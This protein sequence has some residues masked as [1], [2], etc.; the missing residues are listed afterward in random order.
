MLPWKAGATATATTAAATK[1]LKLERKPYKICRD[2]DVSED[3]RQS[4]NLK[5]GQFARQ[6]LNKAKK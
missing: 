6:I 1:E 4:F 2:P 3:L 5:A